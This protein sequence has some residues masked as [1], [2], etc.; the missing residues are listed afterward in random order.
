MKIIRCNINICVKNSAKIYLKCNATT[1]LRLPRIKMEFSLYIHSFVRSFFRWFVS[2]SYF[3]NLSPNEMWECVTEPMKSMNLTL[4]INWMRRAPR[5]MKSA[6][7]TGRARTLFEV[8]RKWQECTTLINA[9]AVPIHDKS[10]SKNNSIF[11]N[12]R[13][14]LK[15]ELKRFHF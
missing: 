5:S 8:H 1:V 9:I 6:C 11:A 14:A 3:D 13:L 15:K 2:V 7:A 12:T 4:I 10:I